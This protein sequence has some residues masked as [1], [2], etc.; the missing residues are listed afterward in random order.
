MT[1]LN[2]LLFFCV[3]ELK[4]HRESINSKYIFVN[5]ISNQAEISGFDIYGFNMREIDADRKRKLRRCFNEFEKY[6]F[7]RSNTEVT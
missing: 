7:R 4:K 6:Y 2:I 3:A 5:V 1:H